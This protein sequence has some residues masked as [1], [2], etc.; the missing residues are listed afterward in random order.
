MSTISTSFAVRFLRNGDLITSE[1]NVVNNAGQ[2]SALFQVIDS[3]SGS[4]VPDWTKEENQPILSITLRSAVG[5]PI[6]ITEISWYYDG[7]LLNFAFAG[8][9]W[10]TA[11][12]NDAF[13]ACIKNNACLLRIVKN[14]ASPTV[15]SNMTISYAVSYKSNSM[16]DTINGSADI[17]IQ[18]SGSDSHVL[19]I[20]TDRVS[21]DS[22]SG[23]D[24]ATLKATAVYGITA[25]TIGS[26]GYT[27]EWYQDGTKL[28]ETTDTLVV[29]RDMVNGGS[30]FV[31]K[32]YK[33]GNLV[34][35][36]GQRINDIADEYQIEYI[37]TSAGSNYVSIGHNATFN[38]KLKRNG[39]Y[40]TPENLRFSYQIYNAL[41]NVTGTGTNTSVVTV[42]PDDCKIGSGTD[43]TYGEVDVLVSAE[44]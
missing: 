1:K 15:L 36:D 41:G 23:T 34:A 3:L 32:L 19:Q 22:G 5:Y 2:G 42:T 31:A 14:I 40:F 12:N 4:V 44:F 26:N 28:S 21:I 27:I 18:Q 39:E 17:L 8:E 7:T 11:S 38:L 25:V 6:Y 43:T 30:I 10:V 16:S 35:Q 20:V 33:D 37:P 9:T 29:T 24:T 13:Q